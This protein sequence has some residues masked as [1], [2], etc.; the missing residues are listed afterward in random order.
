M[1]QLNVVRQV[2]VGPPVLF[3]GGPPQV[4]AM[5][6]GYYLVQY[7]PQ[8]RPRNHIVTKDRRC[9]C[10]LRADVRPPVAY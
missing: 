10:A 5:P 1:S 9:A 7:S 6:A 8:V 4:T 2:E 3:G